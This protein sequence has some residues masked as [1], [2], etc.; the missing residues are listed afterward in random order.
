[1]AIEAAFRQGN[2]DPEQLRALVDVAAEAGPSCASSTSRATPETPPLLTAEQIAR[3][4]ELRGHGA[5][6]PGSAVP[7]AY[8]PVMWRRHNNCE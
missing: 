3:Y 6:D 4:N 2:L 7:E 8:G 1:M 5:A